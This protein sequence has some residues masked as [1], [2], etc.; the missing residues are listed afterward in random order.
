MRVSTSAM[1]DAKQ[2]LIVYQSRSG[3]T[4]S[5]ARAVLEGATAEELPGVAARL[6]RCFDAGPGDVRAARAVILG[7]PEN[8]GYM[9]GAM[10]DFLERI[11][12]PLLE[13]TQGLPWALFVKAGN[14]GAG[15]VTSVQR[16]ITGLRWREVQP[17]IVVTGDVLPAHLER[18]RE[19]GAAMAAGLDLGLF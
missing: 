6:V 9:S 2:L 19:L 11:Y 8:F 14:D 7:T 4:E 17:P 15:A 1:S 16:I 3:G 18:C 10:K 13:K 12:D 5:M